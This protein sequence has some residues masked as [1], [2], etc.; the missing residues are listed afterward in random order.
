MGAVKAPS[1]PGESLPG[2]P[3][4]GAPGASPGAPG[5]SPGVDLKTSPSDQLGASVRLG[6]PDSTK[7]RFKVSH[8]KMCIYLF[9]KIYM[10]VFFNSE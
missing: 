5:A 7:K 4:P 1:E 8:L 10:Q 2:R 3:A 6:V 9:K